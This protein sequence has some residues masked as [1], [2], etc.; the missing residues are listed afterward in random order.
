MKTKIRKIH[1]KIAWLEL[2]AITAW[3]TLMGIFIAPGSFLGTVN[4]ML[5][6]PLLIL[7]NALPV[8]AALLTAYFIC[9]NSFLAGGITNLLFGLMSY[10]NLLKIDGR[11]DPFVPAD[12]AL[13]REALQATGEYRL[14]MHYGIAALVILSSAALFLLGRYLGKNEKLRIIP[15]I[16]GVLLC[17]GIFV[18][19]FFT[20]YRDSELYN[21]FPV[22]VDYNVTVTFD[23]LGF[24]YCFLYNFDLYSVDEPAG[25]DEAEIRELADAFEPRPQ[26]LQPQVLMIMCEAFT[27]LTACDAFT[28]ADADQP[29]KDYFTVKNS[30]NCI[31]GSIVVPNFG[32]GTANTEFDVIAG[33]QTNLISDTSNS[34]LR[35][36]HGNIPT[37]ASVLSSQ[38]YDTFYFHQG[39]SWFY[40]RNSALSFMGMESLRFDN[41][42]TWSDE[43][44]LS[45]LVEELE[46]RTA[47]GEKLLTYATTIQNHQAYNYAKYGSELPQV[48]T[49]MSL[50]PETE[51]CLSVYAY[52]LKCSS[53]MLLELT[54][55]LNAQSEPYILVFFGDHMPNLGAGYQGYG[56][57]GLSLGATDTPEQVL[58]IYTAPFIIWA[59]DAYLQGRS[60]EEA[61]KS[62]ELPADGRVSACFLGELALELADAAGLDPYFSYL[63]ELRRVCPVIK[64]GIVGR[65]DGSLTESPTE[66]ELELIRKMHC[67]QYFR[68]TTH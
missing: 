44:F 64:T 34:A 21:S 63:G 47:D 24:N 28:Y 62:L 2:I 48:Q 15:R 5:A 14:D 19:T 33:M 16:L 61:T 11:D 57:L 53:E 37:I 6:N 23:E 4:G 59:N 35:T 51:E 52:G 3:V 41:G 40:N 27:E 43:D 56:E 12:I 7:L 67:W 17:V 54:E 46:A 55:Y 29:L 58:D 68:M 38:G 8:A 10:I 65:A 22:S 13:L 49:A 26:K 32:A 20:I 50:S 1:N 30:P 39:Q 31:S 36:F 9:R 25:Y 60:M 66:Q 45:E 18:G 42:E